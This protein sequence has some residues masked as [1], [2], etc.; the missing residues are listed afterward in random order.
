MI[1][2]HDDEFAYHTQESAPYFEGWYIKVVTDELSFAVIIGISM[3]KKGKT[4]FI[5]TNS[6]L[7]PSTYTSY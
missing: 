3:T 6:T 2:K 7:C 1:K 4:A 5:Q